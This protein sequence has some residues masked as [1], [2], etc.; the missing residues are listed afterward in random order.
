[1]EARVEYPPVKLYLHEFFTD[2][3]FATVFKKDRKGSKL[4]A[5]TARGISDRFEERVRQQVEATGMNQ[6]L[7]Q[8]AEKAR[9]KVV[10]DKARK[11]MAEKRVARGL[12]R[13]IKLST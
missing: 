10:T 9:R 12:K 3:A 1:M 11:A 6:N 13:V 4:L 7:L 2:C 8:G 5:D